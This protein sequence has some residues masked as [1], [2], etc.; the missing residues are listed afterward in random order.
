MDLEAQKKLVLPYLQVRRRCQQRTRSATRAPRDAAASRACPHRVHARPPPVAWQR[1]EEIQA[2]DLRVA[3]Y[4]R[5]WAVDQV[6]GAPLAG[7]GAAA[8]TLA[9]SFNSAA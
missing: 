9:A 5:L 8:G 2:V 1:A 3:Y 7:E 6:S 4:C